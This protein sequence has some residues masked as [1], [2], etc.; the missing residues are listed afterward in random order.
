MKRLRLKLIVTALFMTMI[1]SG[2]CMSSA[3]SGLPTIK[4][5]ELKKAYMNGFLAA[6]KIDIK[7][8]QRIKMIDNEALMNIVMKEGQL[9]MVLVE[10]MNAN[11]YTEGGKP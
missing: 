3:Y 1:F 9:Y 8:F 2:S 6:T 10:R 5:K 11:R 7:E 4:H